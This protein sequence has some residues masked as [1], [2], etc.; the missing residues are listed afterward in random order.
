VKT[1]DCL[2]G[3]AE[4]PSVELKPS[5]ELGCSTLP[6]LDAWSVLLTTSDGSL[7]ELV[8]DVVVSPA[9]EEGCTPVV[10]DAGAALMT[11]SSK[12]PS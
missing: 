7:G 8:L 3:G 12:K 5:C 1:H 11:P 6:A 9:V 2:G 4:L 10:D